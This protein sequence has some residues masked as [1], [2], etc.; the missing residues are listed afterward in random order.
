MNDA[1]PS[2]AFAEVP[3]RVLTAEL[4]LAGAWERVQSKAGMAGSDGVSVARFARGAK[5]FLRGLENRLAANSYRALPLRVAE[6]PK[7]SGARRLLLV[8]A[9]RDRVVQSAAAQWLSARW[10]PEFDP[11]SYAY[12]PGLGVADALRALAEL[13][14]AGF[15]WVLDAD[16]RS[17]FDSIDHDLLLA[18]L[19][20][21][22]G[23]Q[24]PFYGWLEQWIR[25]AVWDGAELSRL[26]RGVPQGSPLSPVLANYY[27]DA[28]D[29]RLRRAGVPLIRYADDFLVLA[30]TP[31]ELAEHRRTVENALAELELE[32]SAEKTRTVTFEPGFRFLGAEVQGEAILLPFEKPK[33][34]KKALWVAPPMPPALLRAFCEGH[35]T[36]R[37][38]FEWRDRSAAPRTEPPKTGAAPESADRSVRLRRLLA[39]S[40]EPNLKS[41]RRA[42]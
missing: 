34:P 2:Q 33:Q 14:A 32:L 35:L 38:K 8:P 28:F 9:V 11:A 18:K 17:F 10:N 37:R 42:V 39:G 27:L 41:L 5:A 29:R 24:S 6:V 22:L 19:A 30:R 4:D 13:R 21:W 3:A 26:G 40:A 36:P 1:C 23:R 12:R 20:R 15:H 31:F 25:A 16:I 7:K